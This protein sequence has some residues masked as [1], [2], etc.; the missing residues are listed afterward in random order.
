MKLI[1]DIK[2]LKIGDVIM[3]DTH[4]NKRDWVYDVFKITSIFETRCN[5]K[6]RA[7]LYDKN[8][9]FLFIKFRNGGFTFNQSVYNGEIEKVD[10]YLLNEG[11]T[12]ELYTKLMSLYK[13]KQGIKTE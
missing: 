7:V 9:K 1:K 6:E 13:L 12:L 5:H 10:F 11:E 4:L 3:V 2:E 8:K